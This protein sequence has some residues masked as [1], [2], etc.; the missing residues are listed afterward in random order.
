MALVQTDSRGVADVKKYEFQCVECGT[1]VTVIDDEPPMHGLC[2]NC[3]VDVY[4]DELQEDEEL[5][6]VNGSGWGTA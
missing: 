4:F 6:E 5:V 2:S 1:D 3:E